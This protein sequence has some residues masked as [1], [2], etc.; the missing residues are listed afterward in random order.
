MGLSKSSGRVTVAY[1]EGGHRTPKQEQLPKLAACL[2][3]WPIDGSAELRQKIVER[4]LAAAL[5]E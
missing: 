4:A 3:Y 5:D 2:G 1:W